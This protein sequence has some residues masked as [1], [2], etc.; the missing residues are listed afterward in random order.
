[1]VLV[2]RFEEGI[3]LRFLHSLSHTLREESDLV[4]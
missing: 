2:A 1:M 3:S 4:I